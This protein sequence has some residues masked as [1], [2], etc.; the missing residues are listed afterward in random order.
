MTNKNYGIPPLEKW[1]TFALYPFKKTVVVI[2]AF[3]VSP[4]GVHIDDDINKDQN[5]V[6]MKKSFYKQHA[7]LFNR[8]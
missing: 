6:K 1:N 8:L 4:Q 2:F 3:D 7:N 5:C